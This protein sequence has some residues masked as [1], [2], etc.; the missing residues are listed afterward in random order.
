MKGPK[1]LIVFVTALA[2]SSLM[3]NI[4]SF[5]R[6]PSDSPSKVD[7]AADAAISAIQN[8]LVYMALAVGVMFLAMG[9]GSDESKLAVAVFAAMMLAKSGSLDMTQQWVDLAKMGV[10]ALALIYLLVKKPSM[11]CVVVPMLL[12]VVAE[13]L[14]QANRAATAAKSAG[15]GPAWDWAAFSIS[16]LAL[17][18][19]V[20]V[21]M[22]ML[23]MGHPAIFA[24]MGIPAC[25]CSPASCLAFMALVFLIVVSQCIGSFSDALEKE[26]NSRAQRIAGISVDGLALVGAMGAALTLY[27][28]K[29]DPAFALYGGT[30]SVLRSSWRLPDATSSF[31]GY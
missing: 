8:I 28:R 12:Y 19:C 2:L 25:E 11:R 9:S 3:G 31:I 21:I 16:A 29:D 26:K 30:G 18:M 27:L 4:R 13:H 20:P 5:V 6:K 14:A 1:A 10:V 7:L 17:V 15:A 24:K 23:N 22:K